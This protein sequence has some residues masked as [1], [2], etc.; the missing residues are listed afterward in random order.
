MRLSLAFPA[1]LTELEGFVLAARHLGATAVEIHIDAEP[2]GFNVAGDSAELVVM[3]PAVAPTVADPPPAPVAPVKA[4]PPAGME[5]FTGRGAKAKTTRAA[6]PGEVKSGTCP[7]AILVA[8]ADAGGSIPSS[9]ARVGERHGTGTDL[10]NKRAASVL[11]RDGYLTTTPRTGPTS[12]TARG[13]AAIGRT[14]P[15]SAPRATAA[16]P[17]PPERPTPGPIDLGPIE[18]RPFDPDRVRQSQAEAS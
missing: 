18:R 5:V 6:K 4:D 1:D 11:V 13:W 17:K 12:L 3:V 14:A 10:S 15:A 9:S 7:H 2:V 8:V 16:P